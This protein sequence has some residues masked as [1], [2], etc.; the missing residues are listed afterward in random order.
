MGVLASGLQALGGAY[1]QFCTN[2]RGHDLESFDEAAALII[3]PAVPTI[4]STRYRNSLSENMPSPSPSN[5]YCENFLSMMFGNED[6]SGEIP[7]SVSNALDLIF[8]LHADHEQN[9]ST[10]TCRMI[11][12]G[13]ANPFASVAGAVSALWGPFAWWCQHGGN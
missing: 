8:L 11:A 10:S 3:S 1:P 5:T 6:G 12:S 13:G 9:C 4:A 2:N 7:K